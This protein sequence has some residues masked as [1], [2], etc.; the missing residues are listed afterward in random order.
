IDTLIQCALYNCGISFIIREFA[1]RDI[2][3]NKLF[4]IPVE[5][6]IEPRH[7]GIVT[8]DSAMP[9]YALHF[10]KGLKETF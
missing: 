9:D 10:I 1:K 6:I 2:A 4:E 8:L 3:E 7:I 5:E